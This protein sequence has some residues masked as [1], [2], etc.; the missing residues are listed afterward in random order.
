VRRKIP[1][2]L[3]EIK[4][5]PFNPLPF[6][7]V[8]DL[9]LLLYKHSIHHNSTGNLSILKNMKSSQEL[10]GMYSFHRAIPE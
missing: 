8:T 9:S 1:V 5:C 7:S 2:L 3:P 6:M 10:N 4:L